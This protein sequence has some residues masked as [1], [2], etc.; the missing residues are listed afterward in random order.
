[1]S[2]QVLL[3]ALRAMF[4]E[5]QKVVLLVVVVKSRC[6]SPSLSSWLSF[7][8]RRLL[9]AVSV[10]WLLTLVV[11]SLFFSVFFVLYSLFCVLRSL[12]CVL[13]PVF[14]V[15]VLCSVF[16]VFFVFFAFFAFFV[17]FVFFV[18]FAFFVS[19]V[20]FVFCVLCSVFFVFFV[21]F[22]LSLFFVLCSLFFT[23]ASKRPVT[24]RMR[25]CGGRQCGQSWG[26]GSL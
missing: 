1:M 20:S 25:L 23:V 13:C 2:C 8:V 5:G 15:C 17:F 12:F 3:D 24:W 11:C 10:R 14:F 6:H 4:W 26:F 19:F 18:F 16:F 21:F 9:F 22:V 7:V